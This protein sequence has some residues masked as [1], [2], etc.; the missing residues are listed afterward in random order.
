MPAHG[1]ARG[2]SV[3][4]PNVRRLTSCDPAGRQ[5]QDVETVVFASLAIGP[6]V[7]AGQF[8]E[9][10][11]WPPDITV[12]IANQIVQPTRDADGS[13]MLLCPSGHPSRLVC[14]REFLLSIQQIT[15]NY[16]Q[17]VRRCRVAEPVKPLLVEMEVC[18]VENDHGERRK[19]VTV[20]SPE[21]AGGI[22]AR[23]QAMPGR[24]T[25]RT[26]PA[27]SVQHS[28]V[29]RSPGHTSRRSTAGRSGGSGLVTGHATVDGL[30]SL[31][32]KSVPSFRQG[33]HREGRGCTGGWATMAVLSNDAPESSAS[34]APRHDGIS[35][36]SV[37]SAGTASW[38]RSPASTINVRCCPH[39]CPDSG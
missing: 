3:N 30:P 35:I 21:P 23:D 39:E 4:H 31:R 1:G 24:K 26:R 7:R 36:L 14:V 6:D 19:Q 34:S 33:R 27:V 22:S 29:L 2:A 28:E 15:G 10:L 37:H 8:L 16:E 20:A 9:P 25:G 32:A 18:N 12:R 38:R 13:R 11:R 17:I 5:R